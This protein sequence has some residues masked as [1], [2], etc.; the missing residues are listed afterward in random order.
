M[1]VDVSDWQALAWT[2]IWQISLLGCLVAFVNLFLARRWPHLAYALWIVVLVKCFVPPIGNWPLNV[3]GR[4]TPWPTESMNGAIGH[5]D[6]PTQKATGS[7]NAMSSGIHRAQEMSARAQDAPPTTDATVSAA[8]HK[9]S[10]RALAY[11][12]APM[13]W[14][15]GSVLL[16]GIAIGRGSEVHRRLRRT[17]S[18]P[19]DEVLSLVERISDRIGLRHGTP[20]L[21]TSTDIGPMVVGIRRPTIYLPETLLRQLRPP[22]LEAMLMHEL[23]HVRRR[24]TCV[25]LVQLAAQ[26]LWWFHPVVWWMNRQLVRE[27]ERCCDEEVVAN[28]QGK[29]AQYARSLLNVLEAKHRLEPLWGYPAVRPVE[30]TRRRLEEI[31]KRKNM[32]HSRAPRWSWL[33]AAALA[34]VILPG[35]R[36]SS[37][38][39]EGDEAAAPRVAQNAAQAEQGASREKRPP[40]ILSYG[41][42]KADGKKSYG[43]NGHMIRFELPEGVTNVRGIRIHGSRYGVPQAPN[44]DIEITFLSE[45]RQ[46]ILDSK[47]APYR[48]FKRGKEA[49]VRIL[50]DDEVELPQKFWVAL[51]FNA[52]QTKGVYVSYDTSTKGEYSRAGLPGSDE[53]PKETDFGGDWMVQVMLA[54]PEP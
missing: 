22:Q 35:A 24:D 36:P 18:V 44:E 31:M 38:A 14:L 29:R 37:A 5:V 54:K 28:L 2:H 43:G 16:C 1:I 9:R 19:S 17:S 32:V 13:A 4:V 12:A 45:D 30:L 41:D 48:L 25:A 34:I 7:Q 6:T 23:S 49:W 21:A 10:L 42:G 39:E 50:F 46:E 33:I 51:N 11:R 26:A 27:R 8:A 47:G 53:E 15:C 40:A 3:L 20:I 52:H